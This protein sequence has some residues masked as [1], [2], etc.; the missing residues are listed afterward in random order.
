MGKIYRLKELTEMLNKA[1]YAYYGKDNPLMSDKQY[2]DLYDELKS[3]E[4]E[5]GVILA[6]SPTQKVQ[7]YVLDGFKKVKHS[8]PMLSADKTK[9]INDIQ[10]FVQGKDY[11]GSFKMDGL[12][13]VVK[14]NDGKFVQGITRGSGV[15]GEDV[16]EQC[17]F[18]RNLP[19]TI[20]YKDYL[21]LR[22]ECV[23]SWEE[24]DR[25][26]QTLENPYSHPRNLAAGTLRNLDLNVVK[27][28]NLSFVA[29]E[30]VTDIGVDSKLG[31]LMIL[32]NIGFE[33][34][35]HT[36]LNCPVD[37]VCDGL[38]PDLSEYPVDGIIFEIDSRKLSEKMGSTAHHECCRMALKWADE[39]YETT[40]TDI[41]WSTS[42]SGLV[43]PVA[44]FEPVDLDGAVTTRATLHNVSYIE[45]LEL[46]I[47][48]TIQVY[49]ANMVIPKVHENLTRSNTLKLPD[50]C[51]CCGG[52]VEIHNEN[53]SKT[54]HCVNPDCEAKLLTKLVHYCSKNAM[55]IENMSEATLQF[56]I[57][58]EWVKS[59]VDLY[60]LDWHWDEWFVEDGFGKKSV[61]KLLENIAKSKTT[62]LDKLLYSLSIPMIGKSASKDIAKLCNYDEIDFRKKIIDNFDFTVIDGVGDTLQ[63]NLDK[64]FDDESNMDMYL[65]LVKE[66]TFVIPDMENKSRVDLT[67]KIFV[68]TG[69]LEHYDNRNELVSVIEKLGGK[70][71]GSVSAKTTALINNDKESNSSKNKKAKELGVQILSEQDFINMIS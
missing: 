51:P 1:S 4:I 67:G 10:K 45:D 29:F 61:L 65:K 21:E 66:I 38:T 54:L 24:F 2:D 9:E 70:V 33:I 41:E 37:A 42:K 69:S 71:S 12:T 50:K 48:D 49:R 18:I 15:E 34:V 30:C 31:S 43:N 62:T 23:I 64:W 28:R 68:I 27:N 11:Y 35:M 13:L 55:N 8:K 25:I 59:P 44:V 3:L 60:T 57:D 32:C 5:T 17:K 6:G 20:P 46:G 7:G 40:L 16:T 52:D 22:G 53:G 39:L 63:N 36:L 47:G 26:N 19:M 56:L 14:Y 58:K